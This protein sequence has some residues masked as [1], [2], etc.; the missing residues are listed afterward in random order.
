[1]IVYLRLLSLLSHS[2]TVSDPNM[3]VCSWLLQSLFCNSDLLQAEQCH[4]SRQVKLQSMPHTSFHACPLTCYH[5][6]S[7]QVQCMLQCECWI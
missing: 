2:R 3:L 1:M 7:S 6:K 4:D 5:N